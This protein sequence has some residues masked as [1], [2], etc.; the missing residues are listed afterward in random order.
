M[1]SCD[2]ASVVSGSSPVNRLYNRITLPDEV[3]TG[4]SLPT[5]LWSTFNRGSLHFSLSPKLYKIFIY[6]NKLD[7]MNIVR[8]GVFY[9]NTTLSRMS[10]NEEYYVP[11][12]FTLS[13]SNRPPSCHTH[14]TYLMILKLT[15]FSTNLRGT[16]TK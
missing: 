11:A 7:Q 15:I 10:G 5:T 13:E 6:F 16:P 2:P 8:T 4:V 1:S 12:T 9:T 3:L 14:G